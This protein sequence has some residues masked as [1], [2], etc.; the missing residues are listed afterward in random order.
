MLATY[1]RFSIFFML[2]GS[3]NLYSI[4][5]FNS[6][7]GR[8]ISDHEKNNIQTYINDLERCWETN[9]I[10][11]L[12][13]IRLYRSQNFPFIFFFPDILIF[14]RKETHIEIF[15]HFESAL[16]PS[17]PLNTSLRKMLNSLAPVSKLKNL[18][19]FTGTNIQ[20]LLNYFIGPF[21]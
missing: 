12:N 16:A 5:T 17:L 21:Y 1:I 4:Y 20:V 2:A 6:T 13:S 15:Y 9:N 10:Q 8:S 7:K 14:F 19:E 3:K 11:S 18:L